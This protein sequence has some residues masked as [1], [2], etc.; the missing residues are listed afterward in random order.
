MNT[1]Y[2]HPRKYTASVVEKKNLTPKVAWLRLYTNAPIPYQEGQYASLVI[3][4]AR[5]PLSF[6][7]ASGSPYIEFI[8]DTSPGGVCSTYVQN[9]ATNDTV[10]LLA[11]YGRFTLT[12]A[13]THPLLFIATGT[14]IAPIRAQLQAELA[15]QTTNP[16]ATT[17]IFGN[18]DE[19]H[20]LFANEL[21]ELAHQHSNFSFIPTLS[22]PSHAWQGTH[23]HVTQVVP[24]LTKNLLAHHL[25]ICG[26]PRMVTDMVGVLHAHHVPREHIHM[27]QFT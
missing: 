26:A 20:I 25:Y 24:Q 9:L 11:P 14:G 1:H 10:E 7:S 6:A 17:L 19:N 16:K 15:N 27:E 8:A 12:D 13:D 23:G 5:R 21:A 4:T 2:T 22:A 3:S 18:Q